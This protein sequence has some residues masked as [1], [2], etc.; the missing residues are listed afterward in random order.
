MTTGDGDRLK[1]RDRRA[2][3]NCERD[4][5]EVGEPRLRTPDL[6]IKENRT[7]TSRDEDLEI[8]DTLFR[9]DSFAA[10]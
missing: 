4:I 9:M 8:Q 10:D 5:I 7:A 1:V 2:I 3:Q 6:G